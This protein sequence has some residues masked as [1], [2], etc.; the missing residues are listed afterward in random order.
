MKEHPPPWAPRAL[1]AH[2]RGG[3]CRRARG[4]HATCEGHHR[5]R[6]APATCWAVEKPYTNSLRPSRHFREPGSMIHPQVRGRDSERRRGLH[7]PTSQSAT[8]PVPRGRRSRHDLPIPSFTR[9]RHQQT[10]SLPCQDTTCCTQQALMSACAF[11]IVSIHPS[12]ERKKRSSMMV[13]GVRGGLAFFE[14]SVETPLL[15]TDPTEAFV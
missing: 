6:Q 1:W 14:T 11:I 10:A 5:H 2:R 8:E 12:R 13:G 15:A 3:R 7:A 9:L 4:H